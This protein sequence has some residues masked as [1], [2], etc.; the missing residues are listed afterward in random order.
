MQHLNFIETYLGIS[1]DDG[2]GSWEIMALVL[3]V[4]LGALI[5][6]LLPNARKDNALK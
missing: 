6:S 3:I 4:A 1:P 5:G 2:D